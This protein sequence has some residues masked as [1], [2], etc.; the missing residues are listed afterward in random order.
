VLIQFHNMKRHIPKINKLSK[1]DTLKHARFSL[2]NIVIFAIIFA[3]IG[4]YLIYSSFA[5]G[6]PTLTPVDGGTD[7]YSKFSN[8]LPITPD[9]FPIGVWG[10]YGQT[11]S[12]MN[13]DAA[14]GINTYV[15]AGDSSLVPA[16]RADGRF[17][18]IQNSDSRA[19]VGSETAGWILHDELDMQCGPPSCDGY[20]QLESIIRSLP[21]DG[22]FRYNNF[23]KGVI[24]WDNDQD[25]QTWINGRSSFGSYVQVVSSDI[26]WM[27]DPDACSQ[28]QGGALLLGSSRALTQAECK[29]ASNYGA[30]I[31]KMRRLDAMD[32]IRQPIWGFVEVGDPGTGTSTNSPQIKAAVWHSLIAGAR[33]MIYF[34]HAFAGAC[35]GDAHLIRT[36]C[37]GTRQIVVDTDALIKQLAPVLNSPTVS[38]DVVVSGGARM[39]TKW[40]GSNFYV[41]A[42]S[43]ENAS[44]SS[45]WSLP[46]VGNATA[47]RI[48]ETGSISV[49]NGAF[50]DSFADGN[51]IHIYRIDGGSNCGLGGTTDTTPPTVNL[52]TPTTGATVTGA[53]VALSATAADN[54]GVA[55]VQFK[56][57]GTNLG[58]EVTNSPYTTSW[59]STKVANGSHTITAVARDT[60]GNTTTSSSVAV[61]VNNIPDTTAPTVSLTAPTAGSTVSN[62]AAVS[63]TAADNVG[64]AGVQFK[65]DGANLQA[66]DTTSPYSINWNTAT[67]TNGAHTLTAVARDA[68]GNTT[69]SSSVAVTVSNVAAPGGTLLL[70]NQTIQATSD[71]NAAGSAEAFKYTAVASG[72]AGNISLYVDSGTTATSLKVGIYSDNA[73]HPGTLLAS[74]SV[75]SVTQSS[76]NSATLSP[77]VQINNG[78]VYW[79]AFLGVGGGINYKDAATGSCSESFATAGQTNLPSSWISG[80]SWPSCTISAYVLATSTGPKAGDINGDN[81]VNITDLSLLLSSYG[82]NTTQC[83]TNTAFKCDLSS[84]GDGIVNIFDMSILLSNYGK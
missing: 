78:T 33:G 55:G 18:I 2:A 72:T 25:A 41:F 16:I 47:T 34:E 40:D 20:G 6:P 61:T 83:T 54:V 30:V 29:R 53:S 63:A 69:T 59:D 39:M 43:K 42:G 67:A 68:A 12:N 64:V 7:Y 21:A 38:S 5:A 75:N 37:A 27:T 35:N 22:R 50:T 11:Q 70:G 81:S 10:A 15:W 44:S 73:G 14:A 8:P 46:C 19:N 79:I 74:V 65:L 1:G 62:T 77:A 23:G 52:T 24:F 17:H 80:Q 9:Y 32:N 48:G 26:Y 36:N 4:G 66:E 49:T 3:A 57:D 56:V 71:N 58:F 13:L 76:W 82:Q 51:S 60:S 31:D 84:P 45:T 28:F